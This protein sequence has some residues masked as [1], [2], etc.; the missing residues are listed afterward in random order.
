MRTSDD[1]CQ[2]RELLSHRLVGD[3][4][5]QPTDDDAGLQVSE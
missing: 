4:V 3:Q 1:L 5:V 2:R